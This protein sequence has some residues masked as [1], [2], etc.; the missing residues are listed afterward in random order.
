[1]HRRG[2]ETR[3]WGDAS[4]SHVCFRVARLHTRCFRVGAAAHRPGAA[5]CWASVSN[6]H[7]AGAPV[8]RRKQVRQQCPGTR[9][10]R[11]PQPPGDALRGERGVAP[12][13]QQLLSPSSAPPGFSPCAAP[14][15]SVH[16]ASCC[17]ASIIPAVGCARRILSYPRRHDTRPLFRAS[18]RLYPSLVAPA[19]F[20]GLDGTRQ[21]PIALLESVSR[22]P[23][24]SSYAQ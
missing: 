19:T 8:R 1:M 5:D 9:D 17:S 6:E 11:A 20:S 7:C 12:G 18:R 13:K 16:L 3:G 15:T 22:T 2:A 23:P 14:P 4:D 21:G 10:T 24:T